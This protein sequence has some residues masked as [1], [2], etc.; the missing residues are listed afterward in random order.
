MQMLT[1][2]VDA[3]QI[4]EHLLADTE[5]L[6]SVLSLLA[7]SFNDVEELEGFAERMAEENHSGSN[8][9]RAIAPFL[10]VLAGALETHEGEMSAFD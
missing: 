2:Y 1:T 8:A 6:F 3:D 4:V 5:N 9:D 10:R 7:F